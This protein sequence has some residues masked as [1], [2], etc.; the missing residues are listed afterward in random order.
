MKQIFVTIP[1]MPVDEARVRATMEYLGMDNRSEF[2]RGCIRLVGDVPAEDAADLRKK[3]L[4]AAADALG[5]QL[6]L[7]NAKKELGVNLEY[8]EDTEAK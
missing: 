2:I 8:A 5:I 3:M 7:N 4:A 1:L 6:G